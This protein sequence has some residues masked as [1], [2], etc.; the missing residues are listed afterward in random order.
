MI[1]IPYGDFFKF[2]ESESSVQHG[3]LDDAIRQAKYVIAVFNKAR[4]NG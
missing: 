3:A 2:A 1:G 4:G